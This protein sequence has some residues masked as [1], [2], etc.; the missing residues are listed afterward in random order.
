MLLVGAAVVEVSVAGVTGASVVVTLLSVIFNY[1]I[2]ALTTVFV[3][4][5]RKYL[6]RSSQRDATRFPIFT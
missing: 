6:I 5:N 2:P 4:G 1:F 3:C